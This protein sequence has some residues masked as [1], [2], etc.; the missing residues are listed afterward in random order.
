MN[1]MGEWK[2]LGIKPGSVLLYY[3]IKSVGGELRKGK[4]M[5]ESEVSDNLELLG[6][7]STFL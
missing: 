4:C 3:A 7:V 2:L 5:L 1:S 6:I